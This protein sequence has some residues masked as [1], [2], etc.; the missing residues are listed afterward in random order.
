M[1]HRL[2]T[3][4]AVEPVSLTDMREHLGIIQEAD[5][6]RDNVLSGR[7]ISA[8]QWAEHYTRLAFVSQTW[9]AISVDFPY[10]PD[11]FSAVRLKGPVQSVT[12][13]KYT[14]SDGTQL[15]LSSGAYQLSIPSGYV[16]P[17]Y[18]VEWP[19]TRAQLD[20]V[21]IEYICGYGNAADVP[22]AIKEAIRFIVGQWE[23]FQSS[24]EGATR[25]FTIPHAAKQLLDPYVD[26]R[27]A[28]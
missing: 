20:S 25:P 1:I 22:E 19:E 16:T 17:A 26:L 28:F 3:G 4:P 11:E 9:L 7:I 2:K 18:G 21:Q 15:T 5:T 6:S 13:V 12:S 10:S 24:I 8:R 14:D 27:E 23:V